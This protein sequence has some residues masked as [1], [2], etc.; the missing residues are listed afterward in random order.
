MCARFYFFQQSIHT[1]IPVF[2]LF[3]FFLR[4]C[5]PVIRETT[6]PFN[7]ADCL[8]Q[9]GQMGV[10]RYAGSHR[11]PT[12]PAAQCFGC[13]FLVQ[14]YEPIYKLAVIVPRAEI[15]P[16]CKS[17]RLPA[18]I[19]RQPNPGNRSSQ[20]GHRAAASSPV[21]SAPPPPPPSLLLSFLFL[22]GPPPPPALLATRSSPAKSRKPFSPSRFW[23]RF[24]FF[25]PRREGV[26]ENNRLI[27]EAATNPR[28]IAPTESVR[29]IFCGR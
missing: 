14:I 23:P 6:I 17:K 1:V 29:S 15:K 4:M 18:F 3:F 11:S 16:S 5:L 24:V 9:L 10:R 21:H 2:F 13:P 27:C 25:R 19:K 20:L 12:I 26:V 28:F 7:G 22:F 8:I